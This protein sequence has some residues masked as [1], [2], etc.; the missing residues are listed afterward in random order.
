MHGSK[1]I[2]YVSKT[3]LFVRFSL[4]T[5]FPLVIV[6]AVMGHRIKRFYII[7]ILN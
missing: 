5:V 6:M 4:L 3:F 7:T 2:S 1:P